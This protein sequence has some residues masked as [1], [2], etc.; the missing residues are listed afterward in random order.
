MVGPWLDLDSRD[1]LP[2]PLRTLAINATIKLLA[3]DKMF[4]RL[5]GGQPI[6]LTHSGTTLGGAGPILTSEAPGSLRLT[7]ER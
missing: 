1:L 5:Q 6:D 2:V 4:A 3:Y 7:A